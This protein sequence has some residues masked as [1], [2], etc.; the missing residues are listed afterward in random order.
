MIPEFCERYKTDI[1]IYH[2]KSNRILLGSVNER[3]ICFYIHKI[4]FCSIWMEF[5]KNILLN[6]VEQVERNFKD[7]ESK[8]NEHN[9]SPRICYTF[10]EQNKAD[11]VENVSV[12]DLE[13]YNNQKY[14]E[15]NATG[16]YD[17]NRLRDKWDST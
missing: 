5:R 11:Q 3:S 10:P 8:I 6:A 14:A 4:D 7:V 17:A 12:F 2:V 13:T 9:L 1:G 15:T 16:L